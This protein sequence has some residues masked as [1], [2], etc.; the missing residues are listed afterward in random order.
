MR[1][2][3][4][5]ADP[6]YRSLGSRVGWLL[7]VVADQ[8]YLKSCQYCGPRFFF[9]VWCRVP[10]TDLNTIFVSKP[11]G[12]GLVGTGLHEVAAGENRRDGAPSGSCCILYPG[13]VPREASDAGHIFLLVSA[14]TDSHDHIALGFYHGTLFLAAP[15]CNMRV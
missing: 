4:V 13:K 6:R 1:L 10:S 9:K 14:G 7:E 3:E 2:F 15:M 11:I 12:V 5:V 8:R